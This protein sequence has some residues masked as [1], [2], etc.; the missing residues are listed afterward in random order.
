MAVQE[1]EN[2]FRY[3]VEMYT[4]DNRIC[5]KQWLDNIYILKRQLISIGIIP[6]KD[7]F[8]SR[9]KLKSNRYLYFCLEKVKEQ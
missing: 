3:R 6:R 9:E 2:I 7:G 5:V 8:A 1:K 4:L